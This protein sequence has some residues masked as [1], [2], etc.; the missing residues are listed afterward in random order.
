M[1]D[2]ML[3]LPSLIAIASLALLLVPIGP[4]SLHTL[5][6]EPPSPR[7]SL[8]R[9]A[10]RASGGAGLIVALSWLNSANH[11]AWWILLAAYVGV[12]VG[13]AGEVS[14]FTLSRRLRAGRSEGP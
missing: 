7:T 12:G 6:D 9:L 2:D 10:L 3:L 1:S 14:R 5:G 8:L 13:L 4:R 11:W